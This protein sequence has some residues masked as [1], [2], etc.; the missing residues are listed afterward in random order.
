MYNIE[1]KLLAEYLRERN[2]PTVQF[3]T[4]ASSMT[5][6]IRIKFNNKIYF[7]KSTE[8]KLYLIKKRERDSQVLAFFTD[9][10]YHAAG[11]SKE[12]KLYL[13][14]KETAFIDKLIIDLRTYIRP[15]SLNFLFEEDTECL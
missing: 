10:A 2:D 9:N 1:L 6:N 14:D 5:P 3:C 13:T 12:I 11:Y 15:N 4:E 7:I 8:K